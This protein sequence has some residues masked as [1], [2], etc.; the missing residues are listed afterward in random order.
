MMTCFKAVRTSFIL[1]K[2]GSGSDAGSSEY[3]IKERSIDF[4]II[5][6]NLVCDDHRRAIHF[7]GDFA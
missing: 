6:P 5:P 3:G 1:N 2:I 7:P 4:K